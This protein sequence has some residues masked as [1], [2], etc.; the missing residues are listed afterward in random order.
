VDPGSVTLTNAMELDEFETLFREYQGPVYG[1][2]VRMVRDRATA[3][4]LTIE[5]FYRVWRHREKYDSLRSFGAWTR[6]IATNVAVDYLK[7]R[8]KEV[9]LPES[10]ASP[11]SEEASGGE[12]ERALA[13]LPG[14]LRALVTMALIEE[15]P[16]EEIA[17]AFH[18]PV[19]T[20]KTRLHRA[21]D[22]LRRKLEVLGGKR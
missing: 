11:R 19:G 3:E 17:A 5:T 6:R 10:L 8:R 4:D 12:A 1:W 20:V 14:E 22:L 9:A 7:T 15:V 18:L 2:I 13:S 21:V 16:R